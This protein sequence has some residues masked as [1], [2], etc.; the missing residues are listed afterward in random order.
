[1]VKI[2]TGWSNPGGSTTAFINLC[3][4]FNNNGIECT[5]YGPH[6]WH[7]D[8]CNGQLLTN[9]SLKKED[10]LIYHFLDIRKTRPPVHRFIL[11]LHEKEL[12]PLQKKPT[13]IFDKIHFLNKEQIK[14]HKAHTIKKLS[15]FICGNVVEK[16][17]PKADKKRV[18]G[19]IGSID[20][21][22]Q[23][24]ISISRALKDNH[25]DIR[26][27]GSNNDTDYWTKEV[28][29]LIQKNPN[30]IKYVGYINDK[31]SI[32]NEVTDVY[33]SSLSENASLVY[34]ECRKTEVNFHGNKNIVQQDMW[35][36][37]AILKCWKQHLDL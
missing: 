21:N 1:M 35:T 25:N 6:A 19:I 33:H 29:P 13:H 18:A 10:R 11:S 3:N 31:Q 9:I 26:I 34:D 30:K 17:Q 4:L 24:H 36:D 8:K 37:S 32:Y 22:K 5:M 7:T 28:Y 12:Y 27:Y 20:R 14:W 2:L 15:W 16:L 23:V